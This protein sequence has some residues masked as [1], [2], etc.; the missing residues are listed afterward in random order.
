MK[1]LTSLLLLL[2][3]LVSCK[4]SR[5][6]PTDFDYGK[7]EN[8]IYS[9]KY[10]DF[11]LPVPPTWV[12]QNKEQVQQLQQEG[13][14]M[15]AEKN[16]TLADEIKTSE[17]STATLL[18]VFK[19]KM[20]SITGQFNHSFTVM[21]ENLHG[22]TN[23]KTAEDY[24]KQA[25]KTMQKSNMQFRFPNEMYTIK[26]GNHE[27]NAMDVIV[28]TQGIDVHQTYYVTIEK[29]FALAVIASYVTDEQKKEIADIL[30]GFR[31]H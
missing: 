6:I 8:N 26:L 22:V 20:D 12:I 29:G 11:E 23:I 1:S 30:N 15:I 17:V 28:T 25:K 24:H 21:A 7:T 10:F 31:F 3:V 2:T 13:R 19:N 27:F 14:K 5:K 18:V 4:Q 9:N 16:K